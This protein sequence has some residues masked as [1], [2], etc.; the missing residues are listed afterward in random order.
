MA[1]VMNIITVKRLELPCCFYTILRES[2]RLCLSIDSL[3]T[4]CLSLMSSRIQLITGFC[5][6]LEPCTFC[7]IQNTLHQLGLLILRIAL[8]SE[9]FCVSNSWTSSATWHSGIFV[10]LV[11]AKEVSHKGGGS[12]RFLALIISGSL[13][14]GWLLQSLL[15]AWAHTSSILFQLVKC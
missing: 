7:F 11:Q 2:L 12:D 13:F 3:M 10:N 4:L 1:Q 14:A 6:G 8:F 15:N 9:P 5:W